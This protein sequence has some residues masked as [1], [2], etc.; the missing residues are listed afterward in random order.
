MN[1]MRYYNIKVYRTDLDGTII[2]NS[3]GNN[4]KIST[5]ESD[6]NG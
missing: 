5:M 6:I 4:I 1:K 3:D 2:V